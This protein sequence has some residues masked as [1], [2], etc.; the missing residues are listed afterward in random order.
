M[1]SWFGLINQVSYA[2]AAT[3]RT[4]Q[5]RESLKPGTPFIWNDK[6]NQLFE[7]SKLAIISE[8]ENGVRIFDK[9]KPTCLATDRSKTGIGYW[10]FQKHCKCPSKDPFCCHT[11]WKVRL[12]ESR[13]THAAE[14]RYAPIEGEALA[15]ADTLDKARFFVLGCSNLIVAYDRSLKEISLTTGRLKKSPMADSGTSRKK[16]FDTSFAWCIYPA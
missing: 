4:L 1:R 6:F 5:F 13:F 12:V 10:L 9:S 7:E 2:F 8:I 16:R 3:E 14:S 15:V 11:G